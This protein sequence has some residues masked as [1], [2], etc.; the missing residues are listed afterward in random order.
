MADRLLI[1][2][3]NRTIAVE[4]GL[5]VEP[6]GRFDTVLRFPDA[7]VRPGLINAHEHL[8]RNHYG[9]LGQPPYADAYDWAADIHRRHAAEIAAGRALPLR[10]ALLVG[11]W[12][13]LFAGVTTLVHHDPW[14]SEFDDV[15]PLRVLA[16]PSAD[17]LGMTPD[18]S[19]IQR[20]RPFA[21]H[22][23]EGTSARASDEVFELHARRLLNASCLAVHGVGLAGEGLE[24]FRRSGAALV[25]CP[26]SNAFLFGRTVRGDLLHEGVDVLLGSDSLL[27][28]AGDLLDELRAA[29]ATGLLSD[30]RLEA[31]VGAV[32]AARLGCAAPSLAPG[33]PA[34]LAVIA[35]PLLEA[36]AADVR[37]VVVAGVPRVAEPGLADMLGEGE[38]RTIGGVSRWTNSAA[39]A[40]R[41]NEPVAYPEGT[42]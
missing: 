42:T 36:R 38:V 21:V 39:S 28:S 12:K 18:L 33:S 17:S 35:K 26:T 37:L 27:T 10:E 32:A 16:I 30:A 9:R 5:I 3:R 1:E 23:A 20:G 24:L 19:G 11:A 4:N 6:A 7:D 15:F 40:V 14:Q 2:A 29:R 22:L 34:D 8:H 31:S 25:W 13:N 41:R